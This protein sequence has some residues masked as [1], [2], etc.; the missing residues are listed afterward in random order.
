MQY[1]WLGQG[2]FFFAFHDGPLV[3]I[4][5]Y[6]SNSVPKQRKMPVDPEWFSLTPDII[7]CT[8]NHLDH[9]D[10]ESLQP[11]LSRQKPITV[12]APKNAWNTLRALPYPQHNYVEFNAGREWSEN[13]LHIR[14]VPA[15]HSDESAI[16]AVFTYEENATYITGDTLYDERIIS[17]VSQPIDGLFICINGTGNNMN[18]VD[19]ARFSQKINPRYTVP[20]H[21]GMFD[22]IDPQSFAHLCPQTKIPVLGKEFNDESY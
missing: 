22:T 8:H 11:F 14:A 15:A 21:F 1:R 9:T 3:L 18:F 17:A 5:P 13:G 2:G 4:D 19:A 20:M 16:G 12:L 7:L 10:P 6:L